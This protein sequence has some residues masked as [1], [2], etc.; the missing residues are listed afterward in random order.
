M[1]ANSSG[2]ALHLSMS[3]T[4]FHMVALFK[5]YIFILSKIVLLFENINFFLGFKL[6]VSPSLLICPM[7]LILSSFSIF[8][9][10]L[11]DNSTFKLFSK[12]LTQLDNK[13][14]RIFPNKLCVRNLAFMASFRRVHY[15]FY[16][17]ISKL[18]K[19][20]AI[21]CIHYKTL[22]W[23]PSI[24]IFFFYF[25]GRNFAFISNLLPKY[26][27]LFLHLTSFVY[28]HWFVQHLV[29]FGCRQL[30]YT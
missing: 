10:E 12:W 16:F 22:N 30:S 15:F 7:S 21:I 8:D 19:N 1:A 27:G 9:D 4:P 26:W 23:I 25:K 20:E 14:S 6:Y 29:F 5:L 28:L 24:F 18:R 17:I 2:K 13:M 3:I 11:K